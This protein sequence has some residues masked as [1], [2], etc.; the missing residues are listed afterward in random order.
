MGDQYSVNRRSLRDAS[1]YVLKA[2]GSWDGTANSLGNTKLAPDDL[3]IIGKKTNVVSAYNSGVDQVWQKIDEG[4][5]NLLMMQL[6]LD[7]VAAA[8]GRAEDKSIE[9]LRKLLK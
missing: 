7:A 8:Y 2:A 3:G 6:A 1:Q 4:V 5:R 9:E